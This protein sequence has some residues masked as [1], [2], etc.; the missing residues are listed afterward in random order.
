VLTKR[1]SQCN[2]R[3]DIE[4]RSLRYESHNSIRS[5]RARPET[6]RRQGGIFR[7]YSKSNTY[8]MALSIKYKLSPRSIVH[9]L[10]LLFLLSSDAASQEETLPIHLQPVPGKMMVNATSPHLDDQVFGL[11]VPETIGSREHMWMANHSEVVV[12]W[13]T[14]KTTGIVS[15]MWRQD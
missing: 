11:G 1:L 2:V 9:L 14:D 6:A 12:K 7:R 15:T 3:R 13:E 4:E 5:M 10:V 8:R